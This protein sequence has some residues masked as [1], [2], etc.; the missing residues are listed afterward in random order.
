M[1]KAWILCLAGVFLLASACGSTPAPANTPAAGDGGV[2]PAAEQVLRFGL[3]VEPETL[4]PR[5]ARDISASRVFELCGDGLIQ[6]NEKL[7]A[8]PALAERWENPDELTW[9]FYL[10]QG[11]KFHDGSDLTSEDVQYTYDTIRDPE[12]GAVYAANYS[13]IREVVALDEYTVQF[14]LSEPYSPILANNMELTIVPAEADSISDFANKP[15]GTGPFKMA[16][17]VKNEKLTLEVNPDYWGEAPVLQR[18]EFYT[19]PSND[20]RVSALEAGDVDFV[21]TP[22][23]PQDVERIKSDDRFQVDELTGLGITFAAFNHKSPLLA[24]KQTRV[25]LS[26]FLDKEVMARELSQ[27]LESPGESI[28]VPNTWFYSDAVKGFPFDPEQGKAILA[29]AGWTDSDSDGILD[30][31]GQKLTVRLSTYT[32]DDLKMQYVEYMQNL[33]RQSGVDAQV[34]TSEWPTFIADVQS[35]NYDVAVFGM[36]N[37]FDPDKYM[38]NYLRSTAASNWGGYGS[39]EF[40]ALVEKARTIADEGERRDLYIR[41]AEINNAE[42]MHNALVYQGYVAMYNKKI[43]GYVPHARGSIRSFR[44]VT[45]AE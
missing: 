28:L 15:V 13:S 44:S 7:E 43:Q 24:D 9:I 34:V 35:G 4:D 11:V 18:V 37:L 33:F 20:T 3:D 1:K 31:D 32:Q 41:A 6:L 36:L 2:V 30:K 17:W 38:Y 10:R 12:F 16:E 45:I 8:E 5:H 14:N 40:D 21:H 25:G 29:E 42:V 23:T 26:H 19:I 27:G 22:L 39:A